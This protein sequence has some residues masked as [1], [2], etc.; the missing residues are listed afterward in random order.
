MSNLL[1][2]EVTSD[3]ANATFSFGDPAWQQFSRKA[4]LELG[5]A[6]NELWSNKPTQSG[7][8]V[9]RRA[10]KF[11]RYP[12][13][14]RGLEYLSNAIREGKILRGFVVLAAWEGSRRVAIA[15]LEVT[16][17]VGA[18]KGVVFQEGPYGQYSWLNPDGSPYDDDTDERPF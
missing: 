14:C 9:L 4:H 7:A 12:V 3:N 16:D 10:N 15:T 5:L 11:P 6:S 13:S 1:R 2:P 18:L 8:L 17:V